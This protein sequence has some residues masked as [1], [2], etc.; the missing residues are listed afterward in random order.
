[1]CERSR[2]SMGVWTCEMGKGQGH[3]D[4][5]GHIHEERGCGFMGAALPL[6]SLF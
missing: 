3:G 5:S 1:M 2:Y 4:V 6:T